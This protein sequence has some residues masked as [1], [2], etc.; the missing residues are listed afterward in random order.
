VDKSYKR[1]ENIDDKIQSVRLPYLAWKVLFLV[2]EAMGKQ[3]IAN[4][5]ET[6]ITEV[7]SALQRLLDE[8]LIFAA[9]TMEPVLA[10]HMSE[11]A[12]QEVSAPE[13]DMTA[14]AVDEEISQPAEPEIP[15][16]LHIEA[17]EEI[18]LAPEGVLDTAPATGDLALNLPEETAVS[19]AESEMEGLDIDFTAEAEAPA[20]QAPPAPTI[21][22]QA[23]KGPS[24]KTILVVDDSIVIRKMVEIALENESYNIDTAVSGKEG[25][26]K[27]DRINPDLVILDLMLPDINGIDILKTVKA[28]RGIPVIML[29]GKDSP[30]MVE[31]AKASGADAFLPKPFKDD[32]LI[33]KIKTLLSVSR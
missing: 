5:L 19:A 29:S 7:D 22:S 2:D 17:P 6:D 12:E 1:N 3:Q 13:L 28:S 20:V 8:G 33:D 4:L 9:L 15:E 27:I 32:E 11:E 10:I 31:K 25:L 18:P 21:Q 24:R 30:Q 26:A 23:K 14:E 16:E